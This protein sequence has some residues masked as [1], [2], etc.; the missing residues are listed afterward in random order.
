MWLNV[1][2]IRKIL[3]AQIP[4][5]TVEFIHRSRAFQQQSALP[6]RSQE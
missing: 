5:V 6:A 4:C 2:I 3:N 1:T